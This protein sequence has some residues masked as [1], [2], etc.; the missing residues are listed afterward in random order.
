MVG[1]KR[2]IPSKDEEWISIPCRSYLRKDSC[3]Y[4]LLVDDLEH[5][6]RP[7]AVDVF[8]RYRDA[9]DAL[10]DP[11]EKSRAAVH[12]L[13][14]MLEAYY[15]ADAKAV[16]KALELSEPLQDHDGDVEEIRNP[17]GKLKRICQH[18]NEKED[19]RKILEELDLEHVLSRPDTCAW[20]RACVS[21]IADALSAYPDAEVYRSLELARRYCLDEGKTSE[22]TSDP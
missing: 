7:Q 18:F 9:V 16:N 20:L 1:Q 14:N 22:L 5:D 2:R 13:V 11:D 10:L 6:R 4:L 15:F 21:W 12:F 19:G 3:N 17:K 8:R